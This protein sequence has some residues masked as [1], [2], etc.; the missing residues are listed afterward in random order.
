M[1]HSSSDKTRARAA[2]LVSVAAAV[3]AAVALRCFYERRWNEGIELLW[4]TEGLVTSLAT[5][6]LAG[7]GHRRVRGRARKLLRKLR[8]W[9]EE[10]K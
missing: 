10:D 3:T 5:A 9:G 8:D 2:A 4:E 7:H 1:M 6:N